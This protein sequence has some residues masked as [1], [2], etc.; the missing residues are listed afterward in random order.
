MPTEY[1]PLSGKLRTFD[2]GATRDTADGKP[3]YRGY[4]SPSVLKRFAAYMTEHRKQADGRLRASDNW[5]K[6]IPPVEY[7]SSL[8]RHAID[9]W[10]MYEDAGYNLEA[11]A[12]SKEWKDLLCAVFFNVQGLLH[13]TLKFETPRRVA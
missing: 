13:E 8:L 4:C 9:T 2:T 12:A 5:K 10:Y 6:G 11:I 1:S 3:D 7:M